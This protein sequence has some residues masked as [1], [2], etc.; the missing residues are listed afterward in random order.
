MVLNEVTMKALSLIYI[1]FLGLTFA[2]VQPGYSANVED[3][4]ATKSYHFSFAQPPHQL[5]D[6]SRHVQNIVI[7]GRLVDAQ[8]KIRQS[9]VHLQMRGNGKSLSQCSGVILKSNVIL[10]AAHCLKRSDLDE[11]RIGFSYDNQ[12][13][14]FVETRRARGWA[15]HPGYQPTPQN[16]QHDNFFRRFFSWL[17]SN[18]VDY[19]EESYHIQ[20]TTMAAQNEMIERDANQLRFYRDDIALVFFEGRLPHS[21]RMVELAQ[22]IELQFNQKI[23][24]YGFGVNDRNLRRSRNNFGMREAAMDLKGLFMDDEQDLPLATFAFSDNPNRSQPCF[25]DSGGGLFVPGY[26]GEL[27][28]LGVMSFVYNQCANGA[29]GITL[30]HHY[31]WIAENIDAFEQ[32]I[33]L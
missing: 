11:V 19:D 4:G 33:T 32:T 24:S 30:H 29:V 31:D 23:Y 22:D 25:G 16:N 12:R 27:K 10:T 17:R 6:F 15:I 3:E 7:G 8:E 26:D 21:T 9:V 18:R 2:W 5:D 14:Q 20:S 1:L 13:K 28:L